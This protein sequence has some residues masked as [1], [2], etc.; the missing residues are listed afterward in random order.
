MGGQINIGV[1][2][3]TFQ[4]GP[5]YVSNGALGENF[6]TIGT[7]IS[8]DKIPHWSVY[9]GLGVTVPDKTG[10]EEIN[11][12]ASYSFIGD[13]KSSHKYYE[14]EYFSISADSRCRFNLNKSSKTLALRGAPVSINVPLDDKTSLQ[15]V[16]Y[17]L[18]KVDLE[19][20]ISPQSVKDNFRVGVYFSAKRKFNIFDTEVTGFLEGQ[21]YNIVKNVKDAAAG[22]P[23]DK[24]TV[25]LNCGLSFPINK[26]K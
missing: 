21:G 23:F 9:T 19:K 2:A 14:R 20:G 25:S 17:A 6:S 5:K 1:S 4:N 13:I 22:K 18:E 16:P 12:S 24:S 8:Y 3:S 15:V 7:N 11:N 26:K 10:A